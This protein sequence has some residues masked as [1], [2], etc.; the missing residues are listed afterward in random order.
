MMWIFLPN[1]AIIEAMNRRNYQRET[2]RIIEKLGQDRPKLLLHSCC[3]PCSTAVL[4]YLTKYFSVTLLWYNPNLYPEE[5]FERR[6]ATQLE[7]IEKL[8]MRQTVSVIREPWQSEEY[9]A[10]V[11]GLEAEPEGGKRCHACFRLRLARCAKRAEELGFDYYCSTLTVSRHKN[12]VVIN[13]IGEDEAALAGVRWLPSDFKKRD[14]ENRSVEISERLGIYRQ[15]YCGC[16]FSYIR[17]QQ[18]K[19]GTEGEE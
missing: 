8:G 12:A 4:D 13:A 7:V 5:E 17:R 11:K 18:G 2:D 6:Y 10:A 19:S 15:V 3:G 14:G 1:G 9:Y 16:E